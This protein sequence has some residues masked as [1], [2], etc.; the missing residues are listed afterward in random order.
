MSNE[1]ERK[2]DIL[3]NSD[4]IEAIDDHSATSQDTNLNGTDMLDGK[5]N[6]SSDIYCTTGLVH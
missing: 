4:H 1:K 3:P 5:L 2:E 6:S